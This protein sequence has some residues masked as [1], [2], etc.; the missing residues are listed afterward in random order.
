LAPLR[1]QYCFQAWV[2][3]H[4]KDVELL[5]HFQEDVKLLIELE[6]LSY[7]DRLRE[8]GLFSMAWR[9]LRGILINTS[10]Y[11]M[12]R[13]Q[14]LGP[15]SFRSCLATGKGAMGTNWN[16]VSSIGTCDRTSLV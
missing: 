15:G 4:K 6:H 3:Q 8:L 2:P 16:P 5:E 11:L 9:R 1:L 10:K 13:F 7:G 12:N 14:W